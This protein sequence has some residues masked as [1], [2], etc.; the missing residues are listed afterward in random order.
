[1]KI[2]VASNTT[3]NRELLDKIVQERRPNETPNVTEAAVEQAKEAV[4]KAKRDE[5]SHET[6]QE[7]QRQ[8]DQTNKLFEV[9]YTTVKFNVHEETE[10]LMIK[11]VDK[12]TEEVVREIPSEEFLDMVSRM[13]EYMGFMIDEKA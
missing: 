8:V 3:V 10:R 7:I 9:N 2:Q 1:M 4:K 11:V 5:N 12:K 6:L 13:V